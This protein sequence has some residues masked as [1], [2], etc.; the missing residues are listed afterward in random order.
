MAIGL[1]ST[2]LEITPSR[3]YARTF[4]ILSGESADDLTIGQRGICQQINYGYSARTRCLANLTQWSEPGTLDHGAWWYSTSE[5]SWQSATQYIDV[6]VGADVPSLTLSA[7][8]EDIT[9]R[10][11]I[12]GVGSGTGVA[13]SGRGDITATIALAATGALAVRVEALVGSGTG[14]IYGVT[15][16]ETALAGGDFP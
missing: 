13:V 6:V 15:I 11:T 1:P 2:A 9:L 10:L 5:L 3:A 8:A 12:D 14:Y 4:P 16:W 7:D